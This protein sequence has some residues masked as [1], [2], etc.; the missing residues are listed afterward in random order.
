[1]KHKDVDSIKDAA[2]FLQMSQNEEVSPTTE[3][4]IR[5]ISTKSLI[6]LIPFSESQ[7]MERNSPYLSVGTRKNSDE[8]NF[9]PL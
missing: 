5:K 6:K 2:V 4:N 9:A 3:T 7:L 8:D 1:M